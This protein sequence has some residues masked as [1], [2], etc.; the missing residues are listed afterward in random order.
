MIL[1]AADDLWFTSKIAAAAGQ[2]GIEVVFAHT[3]DAAIEQARAR[4]P[5]LAILDLNGRNTQPLEI[6]AA[7]KSDPTV[8]SV[9]TVGFVAHTDGETIAAARAAGIDQVLAR[10][11]FVASLAEILTSTEPRSSTSS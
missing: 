11:A 3:F 5:D 10:S 8:G 7:L 4:K 9:R 1:V 6:L 2:L